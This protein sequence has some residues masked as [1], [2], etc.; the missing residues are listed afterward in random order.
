MILWFGLYILR[1]SH[2]STL[3]AVAHRPAKMPPVVAGHGLGSTPAND[4]MS[5]WYRALTATP[6]AVAESGVV[7]IVSPICC[8]IVWLTGGMACGDM[9]QQ[10]G[11]KE[12]QQQGMEFPWS[13]EPLPKLFCLC[14]VCVLFYMGWGCLYSLQHSSTSPYGCPVLFRLYFHGVL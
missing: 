6:A 7:A 9:T 5:T 12:Q 13:S 2:I 4:N 1:Q 14:A 10:S 8:V 11:Q 3:G